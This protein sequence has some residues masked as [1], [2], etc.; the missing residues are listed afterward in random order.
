MPEISIIVPVYNA[1]QYI[2]CCVKSILSQTF[3]DFELILVND[4]SSDNSSIICDEYAAK[5]SRVIV[6]HQENQGA[7]AAR[8]RGLDCAKGIHVVFCDS[9]DM[10]SPLWLEHLLHAAAPDTLSVCSFCHN[11][12]QLGTAKELP[13][14]ANIRY[15]HADY[16]LFSNCGI[17]GYMCNSLYDNRIILEKRLRLRERKECG[18]Y[19]EDLLFNLQYVENVTNIVYVGYADYFYKI[20]ADSLSRS[21]TK[22][23]FEKY[24]E[25]YA[26]WKTFLVNN[27]RE[28]QLSTLASM[29]LYHFLTALHGE[30]YKGF[31]KIVHS[32]EVQHCLTYVQHSEESPTILKLIR[33]KN[34]FA[35]WIKCKLHEMKGKLL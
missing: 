21:N 15:S 18:D 32:P 23:F 9:D 28:D 7:S 19:N 10:V 26:L 33:D 4:G 31:R 16:F 24:A 3:P 27:Q 6:V 1:E 30:S 29:Y 8:N 22:Y 34:T 2:H 17:G 35:L 5:D 12:N 11:E 13:I 25:K 14:D 20:H